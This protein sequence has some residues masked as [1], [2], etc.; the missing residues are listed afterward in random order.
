MSPKGDETP[1]FYT[2]IKKKRTFSISEK[3]SYS[4][5]LPDNSSDL[6]IED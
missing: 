6:L 4:T 5:F 2:S 1:R 3:Q